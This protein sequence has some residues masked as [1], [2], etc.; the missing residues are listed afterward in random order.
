[1]HSPP[2]LPG[3]PVTRPPF[4]PYEARRSKGPGGVTSHPFSVH[5]SQCSCCRPGHQTLLLLLMLLLRGDRGRKDPQAHPRVT[6]M[7]PYF[8]SLAKFPSHNPP[9]RSAPPPAHPYCDY[10]ASVSYS[11]HFPFVSLPLNFDCAVKNHDLQLC[12]F[13]R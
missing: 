13:L 12:Y 6:Y 4:D 7:E 2:P 5:N 9:F 1:M 8:S 10:N 11:F 3:R